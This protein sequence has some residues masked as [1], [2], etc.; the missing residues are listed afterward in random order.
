MIQSYYHADA[1]YEPDDYEQHRGIP[2]EVIHG[3]TWS[4][5]AA[6]R[7]I[8]VGPPDPVHPCRGHSR[9]LSARVASDDRQDLTGDVTRAT[10]GS[11]EN[12]SRCDLFRLS[13]PL[14]WR[15]AT[16]L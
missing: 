9:F 7:L 4:P 14:H 6:I 2:V 12:K 11:E 8:P 15:I 13:W 1:E 3:S 5:T 10:R 16:E